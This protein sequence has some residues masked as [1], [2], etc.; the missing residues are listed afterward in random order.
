MKYANTFLSS[1]CD[2]VS[3]YRQIRNPAGIITTSL[4]NGMNELSMVMKRK[5]KKK[6]SSGAVWAND[7]KYSIWLASV[8]VMTD[9]SV[10]AIFR[11]FRIR[12]A[13]WTGIFCGRC[14]F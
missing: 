2:G 10:V 4:G 7:A 3:G 6:K 11:F 12:R 9:L 1:A 13:F 14:Y 8:S 5:M